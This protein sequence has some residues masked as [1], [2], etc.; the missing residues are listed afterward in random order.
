VSAAPK[1]IGAAKTL[2]QLDALDAQRRAIESKVKP[3]AS[4]QPRREP[5]F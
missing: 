1:K 2:K 5:K 4:S 3:D